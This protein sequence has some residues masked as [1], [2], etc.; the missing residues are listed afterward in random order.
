MFLI[1]L[2]SLDNLV[3]TYEQKIGN[4]CPMTA[5][6]QGTVKKTRSFVYS[7]WTVIGNVSASIDQTSY[8][9]TI[10]PSIAAP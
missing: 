1:S 3:I 2:V 8:V 5:R 10:I 9:I 6:C 7:V 4:P